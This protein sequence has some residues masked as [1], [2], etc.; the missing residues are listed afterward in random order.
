MGI[1]IEEPATKLR[2]FSRG[3]R[4]ED[5]VVTY[6]ARED[7]MKRY[8]NN[9]QAQPERMVLKGAFAGFV[10]TLPMSLFMLATQ[11]FLPKRQRYALPPEIITKELAHKAHV[12]WRMNKELIVGATLVSH[13]GY[14]ATM[15]VLYSP[16]AK[17]NVL[18][19]PL[20]GGLFGLV[21]WAASYLCLLPLVG[22]LESG[23]RESAR[24][25]L[26][27]VAAHL[28]WG[29]TMGVVAGTF[30]KPKKVAEDTDTNHT[31]DD[32]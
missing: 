17:R 30:K 23:H 11:R 32:R 14:G 2:L 9:A 5:V 12:R 4:I 22:M 26:M 28:V 18:P 21:V 24:R 3:R 25:N 20:Q 7:A 15:G 1:N 19:A 10:A 6:Q 27:M 31:H 16:L 29:A 8:Q 13:F